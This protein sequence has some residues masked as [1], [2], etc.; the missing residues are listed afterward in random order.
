MVVPLGKKARMN[1]IGEDSFM[2]ERY[3]SSVSESLVFIHRQ[4]DSCYKLSASETPV[5]DSI[6]LK[7]IECLHCN[8]LWKIRRK[9]RACGRS[10]EQNKIERAALLY[11]VSLN[12]RFERL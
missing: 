4:I 5:V 12:F 3:K 10:R 9:K 6:L 7:S 8:F 11:T 2:A 1:H